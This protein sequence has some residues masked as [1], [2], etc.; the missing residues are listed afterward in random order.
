MDPYQLKTN[1]AQLFAILIM[2]C[3]NSGLPS[4]GASTFKPALA[5][6]FSQLF[7]QRDVSKT[8]LFNVYLEQSQN[9]N[10]LSEQNEHGYEEMTAHRGFLFSRMSAAETY[11]KEIYHQYL[12]GPSARHISNASLL[13]LNTS[14]FGPYQTNDLPPDLMAEGL[15]GDF[16]DVILKGCWCLMSSWRFE[17]IDFHFKV[18]ITGTSATLG[19]TSSE[20]H[21]IG[22]QKE[23]TDFAELNC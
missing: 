22:S 10:L 14:L 17:K 13:Y 8:T 4:G 16:D 23:Q 19:F 7:H 18:N 12:S 5:L 15:A 6:S 9:I 2:R 20:E 21:L 1:T 3:S 11:T